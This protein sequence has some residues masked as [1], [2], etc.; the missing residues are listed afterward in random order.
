[1]LG[2]VK[3]HTKSNNSKFAFLLTNLSFQ[4]HRN[5][6]SNGILIDNSSFL[7]YHKN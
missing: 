3:L 6:M 7:F 2:N 5:I 1:M 4:G